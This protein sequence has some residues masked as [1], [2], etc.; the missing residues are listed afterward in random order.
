M[1]PRTVWGAGQPDWGGSGPGHP[2]VGGQ[3]GGVRGPA[4]RPACHHE[5]G[6]HEAGRHHAGGQA[7]G[8]RG[9]VHLAEL[10]QL[11]GVSAITPGGSVMSVWSFSSHGGVLWMTWA[12]P[13]RLLLLALQPQPLV[14][15]PGPLLAS[16]LVCGE[17]AHS[18]D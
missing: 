9:R 14:V 13:E 18:E 6:G 12:S 2:G 4:A 1:S 15:V 8:Q 3:G 7:A 16:L 5:V 17:G 10:S 11:L